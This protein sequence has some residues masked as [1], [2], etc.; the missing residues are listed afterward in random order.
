M[1]AWLKEL[2]G[3]KENKADDRNDA[4][5]ARRLRE[6]ADKAW[7]GTATDARRNHPGSNAGKF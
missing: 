3:K 1:F 2:L 7:T 4:E 5:R 6:A